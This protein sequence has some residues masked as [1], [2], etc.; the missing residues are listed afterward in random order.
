VAAEITITL[1]EAQE[2]RLERYL[3]TLLWFHTS[4]NLE[5]VGDRLDTCKYAQD[6]ILTGDFTGVILQA[7]LC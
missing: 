3:D 7:G 2:A 1:P 5:T 6:G 4:N